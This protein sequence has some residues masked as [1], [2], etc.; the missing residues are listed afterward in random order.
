ML[1]AIETQAPDLTEPF[2]GHLIDRARFDAWQVEEAR[3]AGVD[4]RL[5]T[6]VA[7]IDPG[8]GTVIAAG[9]MWQAD[10]LIGADGPQSRLGRA[11]GVV[12]RE[13]VAARQCTVTLR[14]ASH[15]TDIFLSADYPGGY[16]WLFPRRALAH[17]GVG[18]ASGARA[19][20]PGLLDALHARL[21]VAGRVGAERYT[22][23]GGLI[24]VGGPLAA[25]HGSGRCLALLAGDAAGLANP[26]TGAGIDA[27]LV[28]GDL[29]G[30]A[31]GAWLGGDR[32]A[33][34]AYA[35]E[36]EALFGV[37]LARARARRLALARRAAQGRPTP[38]DLRAS[39][40]AYPEYWS[41][42]RAVGPPTGVRA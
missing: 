37:A 26:V 18:V 33:G 20:L 22:L 41:H 34:A 27:A 23:T 4:C 28:S 29:A 17:L 8:R 5:A 21:R 7:A 30:Q 10:V 31:A 40:I 35:D 32:T 42:R 15:R 19:R 14:A 9:E 25:A 6:P 39:W 2:P 24:P 3:A 11:L 1:T 38:D 36:L 16:A 13:L 12:N